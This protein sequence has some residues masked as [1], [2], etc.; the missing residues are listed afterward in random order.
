[1]KSA[2]VL[3]FVFSAWTRSGENAPAARDSDPLM[4]KSRRV[5]GMTFPFCDVMIFNGYTEA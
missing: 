2:G 5:R 1:L 4:R 3:G